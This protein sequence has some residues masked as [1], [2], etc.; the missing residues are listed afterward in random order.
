L[1]TGPSGSWNDLSSSDPQTPNNRKLVL[2]NLLDTPAEF[3]LIPKDE[4]L[5]DINENFYG[6]GNR[7][8]KNKFFK[9]F[10]I[11]CEKISLKG[12]VFGEI[13]IKN[14]SYITFTPSTKERPEDFP[15]I[16]GSLVK[17]YFFNFLESFI[18]ERK[19]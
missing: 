7:S 13:E 3:L 15:Y 11:V 19:G 14:N 10:K 12:A 17:I 8:Q 5:T 1:A 18:L 2:N 4:V 6:E 9:V 16:L